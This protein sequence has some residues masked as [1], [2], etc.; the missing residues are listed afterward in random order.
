MAVI[1]NICTA[2]T[3]ITLS[4]T[5]GIYALMVNWTN[6]SLTYSIETEITPRKARAMAVGYDA[7]NQ[8]ILLFGGFD[9]ILQKQFIKFSITQSTFIDEGTTYL[10]QGTYSYA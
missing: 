6:T 7:N 5:R 10:S 8:T 2:I 3:L 9:S 1:P 4:L